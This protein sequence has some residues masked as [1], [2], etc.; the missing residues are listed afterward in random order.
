MTGTVRESRSGGSVLRRHGVA[1]CLR[2]VL[3]LPLAVAVALPGARAQDRDGEDE[4][5]LPVSV[6][7]ARQQSDYEIR[8]GFTGRAVARRRSDI[9]FES[10]GKIADIAVDSGE[11]VEAGA[12]LARLD[13]AR[14]EV[15]RRE[16]AAQ[17]T[18]AEASF[19][20]TEKTRARNEQLLAQG[21]VSQQRYDEALA[22]RD[23]ARARR[24]SL[25]A[26][27]AAVDVD[28][29]KSVMIA[30]FAGVVEQRYL[31]EGTVI[32]S[33]RAVVRLL[34]ADILEAEIGLP[35][36]LARN[37]GPG[38]HMP[39]RTDQGDLVFAR[40]R[41]VVPAIRGET[42][43]ALVAFTI[44]GEVTT[45]IAD[46][47]LVTAELEES[48]SAAGFWLPIR[49]LTADIRGLWRVYKVQ[50]DGAG[51]TRIAF[52]NVQILHSEGDRVFVSGSLQDGDL[53]IDGGTARLVPGK[54]VEVVRVDGE[55]VAP[56]SGA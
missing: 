17:R 24:D 46:G 39:L 4:R 44:V 16:L 28:L 10:A 52:E 6:L 45:A 32:E 25:N 14:L 13:T 5:A 42:R 12:I 31:D 30:P 55:A 38:D 1:W 18:E 41:A 35:L 29:E 53:V 47:T 54:R 51:I 15:R 40:V 56:D 23:A 20:L 19:V 37:L 36:S 27:I 22:D 3:L 21:H 11:H 34:E 49:A 8:R 2:L 26:S 33:G 48:V 50:R 43:T 9:G 7:H